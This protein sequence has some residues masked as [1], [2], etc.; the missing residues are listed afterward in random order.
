MPERY[1]YQV[2]Q[3][4]RARVTFVNGSWL[5]EVAPSAENFEAALAS[6]PAVWDYLQEAGREGWELVGAHDL[7][8][9]GETLEKLYLKRQH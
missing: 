1:E 5:G 2:C 8:T 3:V 6:C 9:T 4:Q 7:Q